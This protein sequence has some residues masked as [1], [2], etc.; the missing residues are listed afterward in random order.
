MWWQRGAVP[1]LP[2]NLRAADLHRTI[3]K[4]KFLC[5]T[6][7]RR[8]TLSSLL[9]KLGPHIRAGRDVTAR[10]WFMDEEEMRWREH[11]TTP[12]LQKTL[13]RHQSY[14]YTV[15][16]AQADRHRR[17]PAKKKNKTERKKNKESSFSFWNACILKSDVSQN[18]NRYGM[19]SL[20]PLSVIKNFPSQFLSSFHFLR[21]HTSSFPSL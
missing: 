18:K 13:T 15:I 3:F 9:I 10:W 20:A 6:T 14:F 11:F 16:T 17:R 4:N 8:S 7:T 19:S 12:A 2:F 5:S 21:S 1:T